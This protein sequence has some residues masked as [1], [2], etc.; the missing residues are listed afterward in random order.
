M[1]QIRH[2]VI[3]DVS[4]IIQKIKKFKQIKTI[5][6]VNVCRKRKS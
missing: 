2:L 4:N 5:F 3:Q 6:Q 1:L